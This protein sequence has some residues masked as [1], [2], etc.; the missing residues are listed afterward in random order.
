M[1]SG[2]DCSSS[3]NPLAQFTK[4][5]T[6]DRTLQHERFGPSGA[7][8]GANMR[9]ANQPMNATDRQMMDHFMKGDAHAR[10]NAFAFDQMRH[11]LSGV[12]NKQPSVA[13]NGWAKD[14][15][16]Q[17]QSRASPMPHL[18][19]GEIRQ[20]PSPAVT[21]AR[22]G[23]EFNAQPGVQQQHQPQQSHYGGVMGNM[24]QMS[25]MYTPS[26][27]AG[28]SS[29]MAPQQPRLVELDNKHWEEQFR[30]IEQDAQSQSK[31][32]GVSED[33][34]MESKVQNESETAQSK[35]DF[36]EVWK[37]IHSQIFDNN[38]NDWNAEDRTAWD[39]DFSEFTTS[40]PDFGAY[41]FEEKN[42]FMD[43]T[44]PFTVG[45]NLMETG[46]NL[47]E[48]ALAF[49]AAVQKNPNHAEAWSRLG[50]VQAQN[51]KEDPAIRALERCIDLE[52]GNLTALMNL[53][54]SY[55]NESYEN[56]AYSTLEKWI[57]TKYPDIVNQA[58]AQEPSLGNEGRYQLHS[59]VTE[60]FIRAAQLSPDGAN[61]DASVQDGLGVLFYGN[62]EFDKAIDCFN[63]ALAVRPTDAL[64]WNRLGAT[65]ANSNR[66]E[67]AIGAYSK[68][69]ELRPSFVRARY[70][71]GVSC[72]NIGC[73]H[74]AA[75]H[76]LSALTL[77]QHGGTRNVEVLANQSTNLYSTL[78][79]I[80]MAMNRRE[81]AE[82]VG[83]GMNINSFHQ[84][85]DF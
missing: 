18:A 75:Q 8:Q 50:S 64:L 70:N 60:L 12:Q 1:G 26:V 69:L 63:A 38:L 34:T 27:M 49:E 45:V 82:K 35:D 52:P 80:F 62:E 39:R 4:H 48:A 17:P 29:A 85:F 44:D 73:Y 81:L 42:H 77:A 79:R 72:V 41:Q 32:K 28:T 13:N 65:L 24:P 16:G 71:L 58:R 20:S 68:A 5:T 25:R 51:E 6:D 2:S 37:N 57:A 61:I 11:E 23:T 53:A 56:A 19:G 59:R 76:L 31:G 21:D 84:E 10:N 47:G 36:E 66:S 83:P 7:A 46:G 43:Q 67:D 74:E 22:W 3:S 55:T 33:V 30:Q 40:R 54:V 15:A 78:K 9:A 14:F